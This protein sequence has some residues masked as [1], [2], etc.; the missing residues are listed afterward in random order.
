MIE[1]PRVHRHPQASQ[2]PTLLRGWLL[3]EAMHLNNPFNSSINLSINLHGK[4]VS[5][6]G[7]S[8]PQ[9]N[10]THLPPSISHILWHMVW[11]I[12]FSRAFLLF[13]PFQFLHIPPFLHFLWQ[14]H[15]S[16]SFSTVRQQ[17][18]VLCNI[19]EEPSAG[20]KM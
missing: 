1:I 10:N 6:A 14:K 11:K 18:S 4:S 2:I 16:W 15:P 8:A 12:Q 17:K 9:R 5:V 19:T 7:K 3:P 13:V 20:C